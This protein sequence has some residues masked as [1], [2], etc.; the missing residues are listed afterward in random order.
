MF[1]Q[2]NYD[3]SHPS[4][5]FPDPGPIRLGVYNFAR[6]SLIS[7]PHRLVIF[8]ICLTNMLDKFVSTFAIFSRFPVTRD[9]LSVLISISMPLRVIR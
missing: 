3:T 6:P 9:T 8:H 7:N 4:D 1:R 5:L 2:G